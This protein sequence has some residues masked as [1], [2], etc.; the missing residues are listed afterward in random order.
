VSA[1]GANLA[2]AAGAYSLTDSTAM[3]GG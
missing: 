1:M 3:G 2:S